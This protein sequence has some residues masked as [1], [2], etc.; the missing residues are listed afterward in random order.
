VYESLLKARRRELHRSAAEWFAGREAVLRAGHLDRAEDPTAPQAYLEAAQMQAA[1]FHYE[2]ALNLAGRGLEL[3]AEQRDQ[4]ALTCFQ[5]HMLND[6]G[7]IPESIKAHEKALATAADDIQRCRAW[8]GLAAGMRILDKSDD[9]L[10]TLEKAEAAAQANGLA[11][12][13]AQI[14]HLRGNIFFPTGNVDGCLEQHE[15]ALKFAREADSPEC[16]ARALSGLGDVGYAQVRMVS[17]NEYFGRCVA[18][19]REHGFGRIEVANLGMVAFARMFLNDL[20]GAL[21]Q[22]L[23][24]VEAARQVGHQRAEIIAR[25]AAGYASLEMGDTERVKQHFEEVLTLA[26]RL[27]AK[28]FE[29]LAL[30]TLG[31]VAFGEGNHQEALELVEEA[32]QV[33][34]DDGMKFSG[35][36]V[37]AGLAQI[38]D[39]SG[40]REDA[41]AEAEKIL[42]DGCLSHNYLWFY[43]DGMDVVLGLDAWDEAERYAAALED[44]TRPE[45]LP[46]SDFFIA[47][48]RA[49]AAHGRGDRSDA[50]SKRLQ[51]LRG[52][53]ERVGFGLAL[54]AIEQALAGR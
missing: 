34:R 53:A 51:E 12:E 1:E 29:P 24:G 45:P 14:H 41:L 27:K 39:D 4:F 17:A 25:N 40:R 49:L 11:L 47:R 32:L 43:R 30:L 9:A 23:A 21:E 13:R 26:R 31:K 5:G 6:L 22:S 54:P 36:R 3:A 37:L 35:P 38:A 16:E 46:W 20:R 7:S 42:Q 44:Y 18:L 10:Q 52:E 33:T 8:I 28:R 19:C 48:G 50:L 15:L 2:R